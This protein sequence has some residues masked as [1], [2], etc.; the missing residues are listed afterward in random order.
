M[1]RRDRRGAGQQRQH[2][3]DV[4]VII[5]RFWSSVVSMVDATFDCV[6]SISGASP[7]TVSVSWHAGERQLEVERERRVDVERDALARRRQR[8]R[9]GRS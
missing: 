7:V 5:G 4:R 1:E 9:P 6:A 8:S 3:A 2:A